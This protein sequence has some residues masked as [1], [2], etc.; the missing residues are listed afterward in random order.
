MTNPSMQV[1]WDERVLA[2]DTGRGHFEHPPSDL[3]EIQ[4]DHPENG[5]RVRNFRSILQ[6]GPI[7][8]YLTWRDGR[9][10]TEQELE[11]VH[12]S[13]YVRSIKDFIAAGGGFMPD[14]TTVAS[15]DSWDPLLAAAG[16]SLAAADS[17]IAGDT[18]SAFALV[19]PPGHH[20]RR[21]EAGGYSFFN[22]VALVAERARAAG[23]SRIAIIDWDV[24]HGNG[25]QN[26]FYERNDV[27]TISL[28]MRSGVWGTAHPECGSPA[29]TG[30]GP[31]LGH[32]VN[33]ELPTGSGNL[34]YETAF[35]QIIRPILEQYSP[36]FI[37]GAC[38]QDA[39]AFDPNG[40]QNISMEGFRTIGRLVGQAARDLADGRVVLVQEG[41]YA[42]TYAAFCLHA[43][44]EGVLGL[45][46]PL[47]EET[48]A[49]MADDFSRARSAT[50]DVQSYLSRYWS[51]PFQGFQTTTLGSG[52]L[53]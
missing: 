52:G 18:T 16:T 48:H 12:G 10:A 22:H 42:R 47:L 50:E 31:G 44:L 19:R 11:A 4:E 25:T 7:A 51:F 41:G 17:V 2:H 13:E 6:R 37:V 29:E 26:I 3:L 23:F 33:I 46:E 5:L 1:F 53:A 35:H 20:A 39:S 36:D 9:L 32:N 15:A 38:G 8:E 14:G 24:H 45:D 28:H 30:Y 21:T 27:L 43:T 40:R 49:Y 34:T